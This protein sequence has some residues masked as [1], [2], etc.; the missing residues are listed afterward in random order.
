[1]CIRPYRYVLGLKDEIERQVNEMLQAVLIQ[2]STSPFSS[3]ILL[4]KK[5]DHKYWFCVDYRQLN[6]ITAKGQ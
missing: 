5:K 2:H 3:P 1:V 4:V 6:S